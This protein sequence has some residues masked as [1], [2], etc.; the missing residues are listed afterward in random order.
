MS[1]FGYSAPIVDD[2]PAIRS[3]VVLV[4]GME[5]GPTPPALMEIYQA[6]Q[7]QVR[8]AI[9]ETP[10]SKIP[11]LAAWRRVFSDFGV[12]PTQYR[13]AAEALL[14][15]LTKHGDIPV[16]NTAVDIA[17]VVA[18]RYRLPVAVFD[19]A[20]VSGGTTVRY[21]QGSERF[22]DLGSAE[23]THPEPG[24]VIFVDNSSLVSARRWCWRQSDQ[25]AVR[26]ETTV[27][28]YTLEGQHDSAEEDVSNA[29]EDLLSL[30]GSHQPGA[31]A[32][33]AILSPANPGLS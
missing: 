1:V 31:S 11:S 17:N 8:E 12:K 3:G 25:S 9:A 30:I 28:L 33:S 29:T 7:R 14:R 26:P 5:N 10:L 32:T 6:E 20:H 13:N 27:A 4:T 19:Q 15:R 18:I 22:T 24:E 21:A 2:F 16:I 23:V